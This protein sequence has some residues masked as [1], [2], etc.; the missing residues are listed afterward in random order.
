M[1]DITALN[2]LSN[3][4]PIQDIL[5][6]LLIQYKYQR[7]YVNWLNRNRHD[8]QIFSYS[9]IFSNNLIISNLCIPKFKKDISLNFENQKMRQHKNWWHVR[10]MT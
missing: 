7:S 10:L 9:L 2:G 4:I 5:G 1:N 8:K 6:I 3:S